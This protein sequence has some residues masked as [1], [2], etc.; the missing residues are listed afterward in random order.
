[1]KSKLQLLLLAIFFLSA[2]NVGV[3]KDLLSGLKVSNNG[4]AYEEAFLQVDETRLNSNEFPSGKMVYLFATG[5]SGFVLKDSLVNLGGSVVIT[6]ENGNKV[7]DYPDLFEAYTTTGVSSEDASTINFYVPM[8]E[9]FSAGKKYLWK[10]R[11]WDKNG[12]GSIEAEVEFTV[13]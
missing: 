1:M 12:E 9:M 10:T 8:N 2:C 5:V 4:L 6:D 7:S 11:I 3:K 13:K